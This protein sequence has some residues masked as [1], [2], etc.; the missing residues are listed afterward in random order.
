MIKMNSQLKYGVLAL[1]TIVWAGCDSSETTGVDGSDVIT[2]DARLFLMESAESTGLTATL[3]DNQIDS[4]VD[5]VN[6]VWQQADVQW[7][8]TNV[9][10]VEADSGA[11]FESIRNSSFNFS[12]S[13]IKSTIPENAYSEERWDIFLI[14][15]LDRRLGGVYFSDITSIYQPEVDPLGVE[16]LQGGLV[17]IL[18]H[19]LGHSLGLP[20][21]PCTSLGNLMAPGCPQ[22]ERTRLNDEQID[23]IRDNAMDGKPVMNLGAV[24]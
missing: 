17:R 11:H 19:E 5:R 24:N 20:H 9:Q 23:M 7:S 4:L 21:V 16:G 14:H 12:F 3:N 13:N 15:D 8:I 18:S 22:G 6:E 1:V 10:T 2:L